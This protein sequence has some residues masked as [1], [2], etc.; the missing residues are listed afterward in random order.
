[1][2]INNKKFGMD[3][4]LLLCSF[5]IYFFYFHSIF[6]HINSTLSSITLDSL[7]NYYTFVYHIKNDTEALHFSGLNYPVGEH[8]VYT[9]CQPLLSFILRWLP[10]THNHLIGILHGLMF[11]SFVVSPLILLRVFRLLD[12]DDLTAFFFSLGIGLLAPQFLKINAGHFALAYG[13][14]FPLAIFFLLRYLQ[15]RNWKR[16]TGLFIY[17]SLLFFLHPY[18]GFCSVIFCFISLVLIE[19]FTFNKTKLFNNLIAIV[20]TSILPLVLFKT[21]MLVTDH[22]LNR[23]TEPFGAEVMIENLDSILAP[24]FGP[25]QE[26]LERF[27]SNRTGHY[28]GH[29]YLGFASILLMILFLINIPFA[30]KKRVV[31]K[32]ILALF[33]ASFF[34]LLI[35]F[36]IHLKVLEMFK[37]KSAGLNQFRAVCRFAWLFYYTLPLFLIASL[38]HFSKNIFSHKKFKNICLVISILFFSLNLLEAHSFFKLDESSYWKFRNFFNEAYLNAEEKDNLNLMEKNKPQAILPL[39][40]YHGGSEMYDRLGSNNSMIPSM[41]YSYHSNTPILSVM[42]SRTSLTETENLIQTLNSYKKERSIEKFFT[43]SDFFVISTNDPKLPDEERLLKTMT[44]NDQNDSLDFAFISRQQLLSRKTEGRM[45]D[46]NLLKRSD[47]NSVYFIEEENRKPF[48]VSNMK[49]YETIFVLDSNQH[50]NGNYVVS[51][52]YYYTKKIYRALACDLIVTRV[53][54]SGTEWL[55]TLPL[56]YLSGFY[57]GYGIFEYSI[58]LDR[59]NKYEF[60]LKGSQDETYRISHF[61]LR[62]LDLTT[63]FVTTAKD[64]IY[65][66]YPN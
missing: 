5:L 58:K 44:F 39:P 57:P 22:H 33:L 23:T 11:F 38:Y 56:R 63:R 20:L 4:L 10:F 28:E 48:L 24:V 62:P 19:I 3:V 30:L 7:K 43:Q 61:L 49:D 40:I 25:F 45:F 17:N 55:Y 41:I 6:L 29:T 42:L 26:F 46:L 31:S 37:I 32:E 27:F 1:M 54:Q 15:L 59:K 12:I 51:F 9:D 36:G 35:S 47:T 14:I 53:N 50:D 64:T 2:L 13:F 34:I 8:I 66:N 18:L 65:N 21:F 52:R 16:L 60:I